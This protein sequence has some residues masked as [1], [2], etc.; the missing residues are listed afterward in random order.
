MRDDFRGLAHLLQTVVQLA[1]DLLLVA[2]AEF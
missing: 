2:H 1:D